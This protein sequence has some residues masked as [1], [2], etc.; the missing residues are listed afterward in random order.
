MFVLIPT[1]D[2]LTPTEDSLND[3]L[4]LTN[5]VGSHYVVGAPIGTSCDSLDKTDTSNAEF[6]QLLKSEQRENATIVSVA[7]LSMATIQSAVIMKIDILD[8]YL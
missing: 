5:Y 7:E 4:V 8:K 3:L 2:S 6:W 1:E